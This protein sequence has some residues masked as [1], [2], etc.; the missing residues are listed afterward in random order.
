MPDLDLAE[1]V[2]GSQ[3]P[4]LHPPV[5]KPP[6]IAT[7]TAIPPGP[8]VRRGPVPDPSP[9][10]PDGIVAVRATMTVGA[11]V[12]KYDVFAPPAV[13]GQRIPALVVLHGRK[14]S[15]ALEESR[16]GLIQ[17]A[18]QGKALVV[19]AQG[20]GESWNAG[21]C[22]GPAQAAH[23]DDR[24]FIT[25]LI[26]SLAGHPTVSAVYLVGYSNG[27]RMAYDIVCSHPGLVRSF[28]VVAAVPGSACPS[29]PPI[30][31]LEMVGKLDPI[32]RY[33][34]SSPHHPGLP[35]TTVAEGVA[36]W[37]KRDGCTEQSA[38]QAAGNLRLQVW[39]HCSGS[40]VVVLGTYQGAG[41]AWPPGGG[42]A[43]AGAD[44]LWRFLT[45]PRAP[46]PI[47]ASPS[48]PTA[49]ATQVPT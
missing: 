35:E 18:R 48:L 13:A 45:T 10:L 11:M 29:G 31:L 8:V 26:R 16:D 25:N 22:C 37:R 30:S 34:A 7:S 49:T 40:A 33:D 5:A 27:G 6:V 39:A 15:V 19:Y 24:A 46:I 20:Y 4:P 2:F 28:V 23:V 38:T 44:V 36:A 1:A 41:H 9:I 43:P 42:G 17:L 12:R 3:G 14:V 32:L 47:P 21:A